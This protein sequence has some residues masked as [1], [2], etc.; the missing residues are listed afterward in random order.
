MV[1]HVA[2]RRAA[3]SRACDSQ[4]AA[5]P[6]GKFGGHPEIPIGKTPLP[7]MWRHSCLAY[8]HMRGRSQQPRGK[9]TWDASLDWRANE[10]PG[11]LTSAP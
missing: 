3:R 10:P 5:L 11:R 6:R 4:P 7:G 8:P 1:C 9:G 2:R